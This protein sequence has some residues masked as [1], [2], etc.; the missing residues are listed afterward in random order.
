[1]RFAVRGELVEV[2]ARLGRHAA[3]APPQVDRAVTRDRDQ[4]APGAAAARF[5]LARAIPHLDEHVLQCI[6]GQRALPQDPHQAREE[7]RRRAVVEALERLA[8]PAAR[9]RPGARATSLSLLVCACIL[10]S[11]RSDSA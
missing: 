6:L 3:L 1:M 7:L 10:T 9:S 5:V 4:P 11:I 2:H 8:V